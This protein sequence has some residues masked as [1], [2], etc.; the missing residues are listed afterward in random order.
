MVLAGFLCLTQLRAHAQDAT[1]SLGDVARQTRLQKQKD[2]QADKDATA[3]PANVPN[4]EATGKDTTPAAVKDSA[5]QP[6]TT[7]AKDAAKDGQPKPKHVITNDEIPEHI[8]P[9]S[10]RPN[11]GNTG[12]TY[13]PTEYYPQPSTNGA[14]DQWK[15]QILSMKSYIANVQAQIANLEQSIHYAGGNCVSNCVQWN[16]RQ[17][18]KQQQVEAIKQQLDQMQKRLEEMQEMARKQG[19]GSSVYDP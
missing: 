11:G 7:P 15:Q 12:N 2:V 6:S 18:Q 8:G 9:T 4:K 16:E 14:A 10:T 19:F 5:S 13:N 3:Q 17:Q 1:P